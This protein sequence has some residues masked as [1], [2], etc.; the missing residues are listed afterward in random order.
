MEPKEESAWADPGASGSYPAGS[1]EFPRIKRGC[2]A[3]VGNFFQGLTI[4]MR[5]KCVT[6]LNVSSFIL[7]SL[8][9]IYSPCPTVKIPI[10]P[11]T[12]SLWV[13]GDYSLFCLKPFFQAES[14]PEWQPFAANPI[15]RPGALLWAATPEYSAPAVVQGGLSDWLCSC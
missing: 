11:P 4:L 6:N 3:S 1:W 7:C 14:L 10:C 15:Y 12:T 2:T 8:C 9:F 5:E 13:L